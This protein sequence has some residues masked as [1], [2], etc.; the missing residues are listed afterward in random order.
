[1]EYSAITK[2]EKQD[3]FELVNST[4]LRLKGNQKK[5]MNMIKRMNGLN[6]I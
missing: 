6:S 5:L 2:E 4:H 3:I 1:M